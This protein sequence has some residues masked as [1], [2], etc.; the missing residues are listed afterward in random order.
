MENRAR[1]KLLASKETLAFGDFLWYFGHPTRPFED[2]DPGF[3]WKTQG[4]NLQT[5]E[6]HKSQK[7]KLPVES[8]DLTMEKGLFY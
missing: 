5:S 8:L 6:G 1:P 7:V 4:P 3:L 2:P